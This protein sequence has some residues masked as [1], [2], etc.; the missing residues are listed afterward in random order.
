MIEFGALEIRH[1]LILG[2]RRELKY[3]V[4]CMEFCA[5]MFFIDNG[6]YS[7]DTVLRVSDLA[8]LAHGDGMVRETIQKLFD[9]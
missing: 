7:V 8:A 4:A 5:I 1:G 3:H 9:P 2:I 6:R